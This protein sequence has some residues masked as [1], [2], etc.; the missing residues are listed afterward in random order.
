ML[1]HLGVRLIAPPLGW[2]SRHPF[3]AAGGVGALMAAWI[4]GISLGTGP[5]VTLGR[6]ARFS[7]GH[8]AYPAAL[9]VGLLTLLWPFSQ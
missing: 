4:I 9:V 6:L 5:G 3:R 1:A 2:I 7:L 8:P